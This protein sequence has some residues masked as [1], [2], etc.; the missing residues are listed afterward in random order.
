[1]L[2]FQ[3]VVGKPDLFAILYD[4]V[5][6]CF[7]RREG[8]LYDRFHLLTSRLSNIVYYCISSL[9]LA[10]MDSCL[11]IVRIRAGYMLIVSSIVAAR[12]SPIS[13]DRLSKSSRNCCVHLIWNFL[14]FVMTSSPICHDIF[15]MTFQLS[16]H[17]VCHDIFVITCPKC[18]HD[19]NISTI[20]GLSTP[21]RAFL[22]M[23]P[24][25]Y[26]IIV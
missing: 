14:S 1:M 26:A 13:L 16:I 10:N 19:T 15:V 2:F 8:V 18:C 22:P 23:N 25:C 12:L 11:F 9:S 24:L 5:V 4:E 21:N 17:L 7:A 6:C 3:R 20:S